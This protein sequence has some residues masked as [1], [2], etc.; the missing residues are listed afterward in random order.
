M[1]SL[2]ILLILGL[3]CCAAG[4]SQPEV[5]KPTVR[6]ITIEELRPS[7]WELGKPSGVFV[8]TA[9]QEIFFSKDPQ[10]NQFLKLN[11]TCTV[12]LAP[13]TTENPPRSPA[14]GDIIGLGGACTYAAEPVQTSPLGVW[15]LI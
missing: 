2:V 13:L 3:I 6:T 4:C 8:M 14:S 7:V 1:R 10:V 9:N 11:A 12:I 5:L 15:P